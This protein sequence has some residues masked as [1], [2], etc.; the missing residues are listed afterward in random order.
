MSTSSF[1]YA[2]A[3]KG[4]LATQATTSQHSPS[5]SQT[6]SVTGNPSRDAN[7]T[8][9]STRDHSVAVSASSNDVDSRSTRSTSAKPEIY[10]PNG[11]DI[12][13]DEANAAASVAGSVSSSKA[14]AEMSSMDGTTKST[15]PR[16]RPINMGSDTS[17]HHEG[18]KGR[19]PKKGKSTDKDAETGQGSEKES[20]PPKV[21]LSEAPLPSVNVWVQRQQAARVKAA[22]QPATSGVNLAQTSTDSK[23]RASQNEAMDGNRVSFN[24]KRGSRADGEPSRGGTNQGPKRTAPRGAR[25]QEKESET[26]LLANNPA[27]WPTPETA[28]VNLKAQPQGQPEKEDKEEV[29]VAKPKQKKEWVQ[30]PDFVPTVKF[31]TAMPI[32]APRGGRTG[33]SRGGRDPATNQHTTANSTD[34]TQDAN[35]S[36]RTNS[37][38]K[39]SAV[40]GSGARESR[41]NITHTEHSR[42]AKESISDNTNGE[43]R[44]IQTGVVNGTNHEQ[45]GDTISS[46]PGENIKAS[47]LQKDIRSQNNREA[48][49]Q[50]QNGT[51]HR[52][53]E[54]PRAGGRGRGGFNQNSSNG[55]S[56]YSQNPYPTQH[57]AYQFQPNGSRHM[58]HYGPGYQPIPYSFPTQPGPGQRKSSNANRRQGNGRVPTIAPMNVSY[59]GNMY[60]PSNGVYPYESSNLLQLAQ[61]QV[62]YYFSV[63]NCVKDWFLRTHM[64]SQGFVPLHFIASFN[65]M[66][67]LLVDHSILRQ[68]C[69][70]STVLELVMGG[71]GVERVRGREGW[72]K[73]VISDKNLRDPS[74]RHD[75]PSTW[76]PFGS[77]FQHPMMSPHYPVEAGPVFSPTGEHGF[78]HYANSNYG[79]QSLNAPAMNGHARPHESQ[80]SATV[81]E[82]SPSANSA[83]N[84]FKSAS[85]NGSEDAKIQADKGLNG[86]AL[87][88]E[89][90]IANGVSSAHAIEGH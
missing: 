70:D 61:T 10:L 85:Q 22:D 14:G 37:G 74:A 84:G 73:W 83:F 1:S 88:H 15:E 40:E 47:D 67:E 81:P 27:S 71:D 60:P 56:H 41:K 57:Q 29:G 78:A 7:T 34:R 72:E 31:A 11:A 53:S 69:M 90:P 17:E 50:P 35:S 49:P 65:R 58:T 36:T 66:R 63:D 68:A 24:G 5:Q 39:R 20:P 80:L 23:A 54:R 59:D 87:V 30:L 76:Q 43:T 19:K 25:A 86:V 6:P 38:P 2:Q 13:Q 9:A 8:N 4:Q 33:G 51:N 42:P 12:N 32:R 82:F 52:S 21:E 16:G 46:H 44:S 55:M 45:P 89:K 3:A 28:A 48:H 77:G 62:E 26:N 79:M 75:G 64:D 18:K